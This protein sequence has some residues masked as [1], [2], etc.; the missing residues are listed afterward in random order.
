MVVG[1]EVY[2]ERLCKRKRAVT[3]QGLLPH[4]WTIRRT[5]ELTV[6]SED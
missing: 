6:A 3:C 5:E 1:K 2:K 4:T